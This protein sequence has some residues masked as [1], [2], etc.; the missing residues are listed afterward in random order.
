MLKTTVLVLPPKL[1]N[2]SVSNEV[3]NHL[4]LS[5]TVSLNRTQ[6]RLGIG[7][8]SPFSKILIAKEVT[9]AMSSVVQSCGSLFPNGN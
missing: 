5:G 4:S 3:E 9:V 1:R 8:I 6:N 2:M 7:L